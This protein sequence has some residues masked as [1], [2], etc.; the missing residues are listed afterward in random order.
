MEVHLVREE[1]EGKEWR[2]LWGTVKNGNV[3]RREERESEKKLIQ[4]NIG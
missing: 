3:F 2:R 4:I 1:E